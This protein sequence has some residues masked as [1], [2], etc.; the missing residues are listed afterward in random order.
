M[1]N[2]SRGHA[3]WGFADHRDHARGFNRVHQQIDSLSADGGE[4]EDISRELGEIRESA[5][6]HPTHVL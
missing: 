4:H 2:A 5:P 6:H 1:S 3:A